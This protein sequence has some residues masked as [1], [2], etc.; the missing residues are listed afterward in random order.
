MK[1][2]KI[3]NVEELLTISKD[4]QMVEISQKDVIRYMSI[5]RSNSNQ[6]INVQELNNVFAESVNKAYQDKKYSQDLVLNKRDIK[7]VCFG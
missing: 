1:R 7:K 4:I 6:Y 2:V 5:H 3:T